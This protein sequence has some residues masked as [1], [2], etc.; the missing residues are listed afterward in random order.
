MPELKMA[1]TTMEDQLESLNISDDEAATLVDY[2]TYFRSYN[3]NGK[4]YSECLVENCSKKKLT[5]KQKFNLERHLTAIHKIHNFRN[6]KKSVPH[7]AITIKIK[8]SPATIYR[9]Y[10]EKV[11]LNGRI[12]GCMNDS[13]ARLLL[14]PLLQGFANA[15]VKID[16]SIPTLKSYLTKYSE[17]VKNEIRNEVANTIIHVKLDLASRQRKS[18]LGVNIQFMKDNAIVVRTLSMLQTHSSH[19][20]EYICCLI[21]QILDDFNIKYSQVHT[22]TTDNGR[23]VIKSAKLFR[24]VENA[25]LID[26]TYVDYE[27]DNFFDDQYENNVNNDNET[28]E[29]TEDTDN[30]ERIMDV[31]A[32]TQIMT[33][34]KCAVHTLQLVVNV[35]IANT[36]YATKLIKKC[37]LIVK[38]L[39]APNM[40][41]LIRQQNLRSPIIDCLTRWSS[42]FGMLERLKELKEFYLSVT[43]FMPAGCKMTDSEWQALNGILGILKWFESLTTKLQSVSFTVSDFYSAWIEIKLEM[44]SLAGIELVDNILLE[45]QNRE[46][47]LMQNDVF[48]S[49]IFLDPNYKILLTAGLFIFFI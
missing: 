48:Y 35:A 39:L 8:M 32:K 20:G 3:E 38:C 22:I 15:G 21:M 18:I 4:T 26:K 10:V 19:T 36:D 44:E 33:A 31:A 29:D 12:I 13:G 42:T 1:E 46:A 49:C 2:R 9:S 6:E 24:A 28:T 23:N 11:A 25:D 5:G 34:I 47:D 16:V 43:S 41:N 45:M 7:A 14:D 17:A 40:L 27:L 37:R 30:M